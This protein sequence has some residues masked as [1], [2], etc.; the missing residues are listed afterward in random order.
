ML[1]PCVPV[2]GGS[3]MLLAGQDPS[4]AGFW[5]GRKRPHV[6]S[7]AYRRSVSPRFRVS[8]GLSSRG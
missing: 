7:P 5:K 2:L 6:N 4:Q 8:H 3:A 1:S